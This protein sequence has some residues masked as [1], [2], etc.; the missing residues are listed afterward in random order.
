MC[1]W[2]DGFV[3]NSQQSKILREQKCGS[4]LWISCG[5]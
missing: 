5:L 1:V 3:I 2:Q 4:I